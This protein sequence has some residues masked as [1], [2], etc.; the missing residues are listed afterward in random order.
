MRIFSFRLNSLIL[1]RRLASLSSSWQH[2][3]S[4]VQNLALRK[5][6]VTSQQKQQQFRRG[7]LYMIAAECRQQLFPISTTTMKSKHNHTHTRSAVSITFIDSDGKKHDVK[8]KPGTNVMEA[9]HENDID[10]E[11]ACEGSLACSTCHVILD[12]KDYDTLP[13]PSDEENDLLDLAFGLTET[14]GR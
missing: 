6:T 5:L 3:L 13:Q 12:R 9:A 10:L 4:P 14:C 1:P 7:L 11:G 8:V 2:T